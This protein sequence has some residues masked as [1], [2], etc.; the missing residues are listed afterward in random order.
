MDHNNSA[1]DR[2][3]EMKGV[4]SNILACAGLCVLFGAQFQSIVEFDRAMKMYLT[5]DI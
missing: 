2:L 4:K 3:R 1:T 5:E